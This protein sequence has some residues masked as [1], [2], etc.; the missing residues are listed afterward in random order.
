MIA[1]LKR[2]TN[3]LKA[4]EQIVVEVENISRENHDVYPIPIETNGKTANQ[5]ILEF[6]KLKD[7]T[8][9]KLDSF[10]K[11]VK[12]LE[13]GLGTR[14]QQPIL[15]QPI[16]LSIEAIKRYSQAI[17]DIKKTQNTIKLAKDTI[18]ELNNIYKQKLLEEA[19]F[20]SYDELL[21]QIHE[22]ENKI[23]DLKGRF[24]GG[25]R[26]RKQI[27]NL[28]S[29]ITPLYNIYYSQYHNLMQD[30]DQGPI[31][32][33]K[34]LEISYADEKRFEKL[35]LGGITSFTQGVLAKYK[36]VAKQ[37]VSLDSKSQILDVN[38]LHSLIDDY[39]ESFRPKIESRI[40]K[41]L[42]VYKKQDSKHSKEV[43]RILKNPE[44]VDQALL[45]LKE[46]L[47]RSNIQSSI[48]WNSLDVGFDR[49]DLKKG[50]SLDERFKDLPYDIQEVIEQALMPSDKTINNEFS[51]F[52][53]YVL[54]EPILESFYKVKKHVLNTFSNLSQQGFMVEAWTIKN[55]MYDIERC[56]KHLDNLIKSMDINK[57]FIFKNNEKVQQLYGEQALESFNNLIRD[58]IFDNLLTSRQHTNE[59]IS[60]GY[61]ALEFKDGKAIVY[62]ILNFWREPGYSGEYP[63]LSGDSLTM[64]FAVR[65]VLSLTNEE[66]KS[67]EELRIPGVM[68]MINII[69]EH[70]K[71]LSINQRLYNKASKHLNKICGYHL[72]N[73]S[74]KEKQFALKT[75]IESELMGFSMGVVGDETKMHRNGVIKSI[76]DYLELDEH[77]QEN[78]SMNNEQYQYFMERIGFDVRRTND[79][80]RYRNTA[81]AISKYYDEFNILL[82]KA[83]KDLAKKIWEESKS[84][85]NQGY[86]SDVSIQLPRLIDY[87]HAFKKGLVQSNLKDSEF[88]EFFK[89]RLSTLKKQIFS[90]KTPKTS[91]GS[92]DK[93]IENIT[94]YVCKDIMMLR[95]L[96]HKTNESIKK[97]SLDPVLSVLKDEQRRVLEMLVYRKDVA[98]KTQHIVEYLK[99][100]DDDKTAKSF[101]KKDAHEKTG[102][103]AL[104][105]TAYNCDKGLV[106]P[107]IRGAINEN[108]DI[109]DR[110][111]LQNY[112]PRLEEFPEF[113]KACVNESLD[114]EAV[115]ELL[116][117]LSM[118][119]EH[120]FELVAKINNKELDVKQVQESMR[121]LIQNNI[122]PTPYLLQNLI[123]SDD[124]D[125]RI[126]EWKNVMNSFTE[127]NFDANNELHRNLEYTRFRAIVDHEKVR[128]YIKNH[129]T[130]SQYLGIFDKKGKSLEAVITE[131]DRFEIECVAEEAKMLRDYVKAVNKRATDL[132]R[133]VFLVPNLSYGYLPVSVI[134][135]ELEDEGV[136]VIMGVKVGSTESHKNREV[137]NSRLFKGYRTQILN[138]QP[139]IV[140]VDGTKH[141]IARDNQ[142]RAARYPDAYQGFLNQIIAINDALGFTDIKYSKIGKTDEDMVRLRQQPEFQ[143]T[144]SVYKH[145][146]QIIGKDNK[147][148]KR[149]PYR[150]A[151]WNTTGLELIIRSYRQKIGS[152]KPLNTEEIESPTMIFCNV[153][154]LD[155]Q[156]PKELNDKYPGLKHI[157]AYFDDSEKVINFEFGFDN[158]GVRYLNTLETEIKKVF[159]SKYGVSQN[160]DFVASLIRY[161]KN[162]RLKASTQAAY[163][164]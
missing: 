149:E 26:F 29:R 111:Q 5:I 35:L 125:K 32:S 43:V 89:K 3:G 39:V 47:R 68:D 81:L 24:L 55:E 45:V 30:L 164:T 158:Y 128:S 61:K 44:L 70:E 96:I 37:L 63:F 28:N 54:Q 86:I 114:Q 56:F 79:V 88:G 49:S 59:S 133:E 163:E 60:L 141:M 65:Y 31:S 42:D 73:G 74:E 123:F 116:Y 142:N 90:S 80:K 102:L 22:L 139:I 143:R 131:Q 19:G 92:E 148:K 136:K 115:F 62:N 58:R 71:D 7:Y 4:L 110:I 8:Q 84:I 120:S 85:I 97:C 95:D 83:D 53:Y 122:K 107:L 14:L 64:P 100:L 118:I 156:L 2:G 38:T 72:K 145:I 155:E 94:E 76:A 82:E 27:K 41:V 6:N 98:K 78:L 103:E 9:Q 16:E 157:P 17:L 12:D 10:K 144:V 57:W 91:D 77:V 154:L 121:K 67:V 69:R 162:N 87:L 101:N 25:L 146:K 33:L 108:I 153:G 11:Q 34:N 104:A 138:K 15:Q 75:L 106:V 93:P 105:S 113:V 124:K 50:S 127:G 140:V 21:T 160:G 161:V 51:E 40:K 129:F 130:F 13:T 119:G 159:G 99:A 66:L 151:F 18:K 134:A 46:K 152:V 150:F 109:K 135:E 1:D 132:G 20:T 112:L 52:G 126:D 117:N 137:I 36:T 48:G 147:T 23:S